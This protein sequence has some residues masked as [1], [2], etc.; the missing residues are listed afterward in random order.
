[1][2]RETDVPGMMARVE[3]ALTKAA[4]THNKYFC[5]LQL[6]LGLCTKAGQN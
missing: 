5:L 2:L 3:T 1:M 4:R 6:C